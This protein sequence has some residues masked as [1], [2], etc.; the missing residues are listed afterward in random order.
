MH[1]LWSWL[2]LTAAVLIT[3]YIL[4]GIKVKGFVGAL[5]TAAILGILNVV[6]RPILRFFSLPLIWL[7]LGLFSL[8]IN[9]LILSVVSFITDKFKV[10]G[11]GWAIGGAFCI[12][13]I[14]AILT[15]IF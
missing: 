13:I 5:I 12:S 11:F 3:A 14:N 7:T 8:V 10:D 1:I 15:R 9:G 6:L 2:I 4:P